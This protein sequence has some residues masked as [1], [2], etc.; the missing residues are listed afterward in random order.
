MIFSFFFKQHSHNFPNVSLLSFLVIVIFVASYSNLVF[1][2]HEHN[3][4]IGF[5]GSES[6]N[7]GSLVGLDESNILIPLSKIG[8]C[9]GCN[10][11]TN[12]QVLTIFK[13]GTRDMPYLRG[14]TMFLISPNPYAFTNFDNNTNPQFFGPNLIINDNDSLDYDPTSG[15]IELIK[16][17]PG[18]YSVLELRGPPGFL[19]NNAPHSSAEV[20]ESNY[21]HVSVTNLPLTFSSNSESMLP[22]AL[23]VSDLNVMETYAPKLNGRSLTHLPPSLITS[24]SDI[25]TTLP[26]AHVLFENILPSDAQ[27]WNASQRFSNL[28]IPTYDALSL[29]SS[30]G[31]ISPIFVASN[32]DG[33]KFIN[34]PKFTSIDFNTN[35]VMR[36]DSTIQ[37]DGHHGNHGSSVHG[38]SLPLAVSGNDFGVSLQI[39]DSPPGSIPDLDPALGFQSLFID[40]TNT[41]DISLSDPNSFLTNPVITFYLDRNGDNSCPTDITVYVLESNQW[42]PVQVNGTNTP[43]ILAPSLHT[44]TQCAYEQKVEHFSSYLVGTSTNHSSHSTSS[45]SSH[46]TSSHSSHSGHNTSTVGHDHTISD[47]TVNGLIKDIHNKQVYLQIH[48]NSDGDITTNTGPGDFYTPGEVRGELHYIP[49]SK[50]FTTLAKPS[51]EI[52]SQADSILWR[53]SKA[54]A[55]A[56]FESTS[57]NEL[58]YTISGKNLSTVVGISLYLGDQYTNSDI[59]LV[60]IVSS[61]NPIKLN[62]NGIR[63]TITNGDMCPN[64]HFNEDG[65]VSHDEHPT[66]EQVNDDVILP[67]EPVVDTL[68]Q[69]P[70][71]TPGTCYGV[72]CTDLE[73]TGI[74]IDDSAK[75]I[76]TTLT[77]VDSSSEYDFGNDFS[78]KKILVDIHDI[79]FPVTYNLN[80][81]ITKMT[82]NEEENSLSIY[83]DNVLENNFVLRIPRELVDAENNNFLVMV[84]A[85]PE[86][87]TEYEVISSNEEFFTIQLTVPDNTSKVTIIGTR[88]IPEFGGV[89]MMILGIAITSIIAVTAKTKTFVRF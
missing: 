63:G 21:P 76:P 84:T 36:F 86:K 37:Y 54:T 28:G 24:K 29:N 75:E 53:T 87:L 74:L 85:S 44:L 10:N 51:N 14:G 55:T 19:K 18:V 66:D 59:H 2:E 41:G 15:V 68:P 22:P 46:S 49:G 57:Y 11:N 78:G 67:D 89:A 1:A 17:N 77:V 34:T 12:N 13:H 82:I 42:N 64:S 70:N 47:C 31:Y 60:D 45:H 6:G 16:V 83:L 81:E 9:Y 65:T 61:A 20:V 4:G 8:N 69:L 88:V 43:P 56:S 71:T 52:L 23:S 7:T 33:S 26:P 39:D 30:N 80:G 73:P 40:V 38:I 27:N 62:S 25:F 5:S 50:I 35:F 72:E 32:T 48:T 3:H 79:T 58:Q